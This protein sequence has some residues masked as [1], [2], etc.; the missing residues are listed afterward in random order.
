MYPGR[1]MA[2]TAIVPERHGITQAWKA[3]IPELDLGVI[4]R[5]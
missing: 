1:F 3:V 2:E 5:G 4:E